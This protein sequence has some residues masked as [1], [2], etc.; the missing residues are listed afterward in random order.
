MNWFKS[1]Q[2]NKSAQ[3][4]FFILLI[5]FIIIQ[6]A[7]VYMTNIYTS[8]SHHTISRMAFQRSL[9]RTVHM[10]NIIPAEIMLKHPRLMTQPGIPLIQLMTQPVKNIPTIKSTKPKDLR[11]F[12][13][14]HYV[15]FK[16][17]YQLKDGRWVFMRGGVHRSQYSWVGFV[18]SE[19]FLLIVLIALCIWVVQRL[20]IPVTAFN[21]AAKRFGVDINAPPVAMQGTPEMRAV[22]ASFNEM[23]GRIRRLIMDRTQMLAAIS[24]DLRTPITRLQ[25]RIEALKG[26][27]QFTPAEQ[28]I[29]EMQRMI[30][31]ILAFAQDHVSA[32][33]MERFDLSA[34][35]DNICNEFEDVGRNVSFKTAITRLPYFGRMIALKRALSNVIENAVKYGEAAV[36]TLESQHDQI[37]IKIQ[38]KGPGI[39]EAEME[40]VFA[41]FYR[42]DPAR[43]PEK[44]GT[45][46]GMAV[47]RDIIRAHG[48]DIKLHN[49]D[50][51]GLIVIVSLGSDPGLVIATR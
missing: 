45:G 41:P 46:L 16:A 20:A 39:P 19:L 9:I 18:L 23:Q 25:L 43:S 21:E 1:L 13:R 37:T 22:I 5:G 12:A 11:L 47:A 4:T 30:T 48:G 33:Q 31:S 3:R 32:E 8:R 7:G 35:L 15:D 40:K 34:L 49:L 26:T 36:V 51:G 29:Q 2:S 24:H 6:L 28:D 10:L 44:S 38:D 50:G 42:I 27:P 17:N 14:Q